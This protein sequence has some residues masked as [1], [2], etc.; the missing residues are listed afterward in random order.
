[1]N[2]YIVVEGEETEMQLYPQWLSYV[3]PELKKVNTYK[4][5]SQNSYY[6][7]CGQGIPS[8]YKHTANA[9]R[10]INQFGQY[11]YLIVCL[12]CDEL[13]PDGRKKKLLDYL[14]NEGVI[15]SDTCQLKIVTQ[16]AC[17]ESWFLGNRKVFKKN[18]EGIKFKEFITFF[19]VSIA[20]PEI[21]GKYVGYHQRAH[22]HE[23]YLRE[24]LK[25]HGLV[26][27]KSNPKAILNLPYFNELQKRIADEPTQMGT[28][29][30]F[31]ELC[32]EIKAKIIQ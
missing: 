12:D 32:K 7:F 13:S 18:P 24:M 8:I 25:E 31:F 28:L 26:Y 14:D 20:D 17:I 29:N 3:I 5:V 27:R 2:L 11:N 16:N 30:Y 1:M 22:F 9:I 4:E 23:A 21:M 19:N 10:D 15:L 6:L